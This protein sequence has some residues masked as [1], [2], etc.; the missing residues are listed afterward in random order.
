VELALTGVI[1][2]VAAANAARGHRDGAARGSAPSSI[3]AED[4]LEARFR[5]S[6]ALAV[7]GTLAPGRPNHHVVAPLG[8]EW[9]DGFVEGEL[10][11]VGWGA[12]LGYRAA[13]AV[14][15]PRVPDATAQHQGRTGLILYC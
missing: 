11:P 4:L 5:V 12:T 2:L 1:R 3:R 13:D 6:H 15:R 14:V 8:G 7:Y 9:A 10:S